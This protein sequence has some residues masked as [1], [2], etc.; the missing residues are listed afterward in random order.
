MVRCFCQA[1]KRNVGNTNLVYEMSC[2]L[3]G[4][5][6]IYEVGG[7]AFLTSTQMA[8][9]TCGCHCFPDWVQC[10]QLLVEVDVGGEKFTFPNGSLNYYPSY[11]RIIGR[12]CHFILDTTQ[13]NGLYLVNGI[14]DK[15]DKICKVVAMF[16]YLEFG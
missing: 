12:Y 5:F 1:Q 4:T 9:D 6:Q 3:D 10:T 11:C 14:E 13:V 15:T 8:N 2:N 7:S 16:P